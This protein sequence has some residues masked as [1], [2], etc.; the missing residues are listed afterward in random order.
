MI[1]LRPARLVLAALLAAVA[2]LPVL[3]AAAAKPHV[4][5]EH[6]GVLAHLWTAAGVVLTEEVTEDLRFT[7]FFDRRA[8][9]SASRSSSTS[10]AWSPTR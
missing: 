9:P 8:P 3:P 10:S 6:R 4:E 7:T 5:T 2:A 1:R